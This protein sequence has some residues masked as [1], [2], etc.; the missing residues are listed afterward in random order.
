MDK[1]EQKQRDW[2]YLLPGGQSAENMKSG[3]MILSEESGH[4]FSSESFRHLV[5]NG[6]IKKINR[7]N[8]CIIPQ[9]DAINKKPPTA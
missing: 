3:R 8:D 7:I 2:L 1:Q 9:S 4:D 6:V 5:K